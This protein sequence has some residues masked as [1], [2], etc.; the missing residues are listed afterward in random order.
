MRRFSQLMTRFWG[1]TIIRTGLTF[2]SHAVLSMSI[3][4][5]KY[6]FVN[7]YSSYYFDRGDISET[8]SE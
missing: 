5:M 8:D 4:G 2:I 1:I 6:A 7:D 3:R